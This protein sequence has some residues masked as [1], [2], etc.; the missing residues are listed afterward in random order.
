[1]TLRELLR[2]T[3]CQQFGD[4]WR[5]RL[6]GSLLL[7]VRQGERDEESRRQLGFVRLGPLYYLT[8]GELVEIL[9]QDIGQRTLTR[10]GGPRFLDQLVGIL[11]IRNAVGHSRGV[12]DAALLTLEATFEQLSTALSARE[13]ERLVSKPDTGLPTDQVTS[14]LAEWL[15]RSAQ[16]IE[17]LESPC[18]DST[19]LR[20]A[21]NQYWWGVPGVAPFDCQIVEVAA[22]AID[23]YNR[24]PGGL[25]ATAV[26]LR[27]IQ[28]EEPLVVIN[29]A[30]RAV[31]A[32]Q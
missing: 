3:L 10:L 30:L 20:E 12:S 28:T 13:I 32:E 27:Y 24:I 7:K 16:A 23:R 31:M 15:R 22:R 29:A 26:R 9:G 6:P 21:R 4:A 25:G 11:P 14:D 19:L 18:P 5:K 1:V 17:R 2:E 8:L